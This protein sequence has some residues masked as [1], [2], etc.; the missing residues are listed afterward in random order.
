LVLQ[1]KRC[2]TVS[3]IK[4]IEV[5]FWKEDDLMVG[6][7]ESRRRKQQ[8]QNRAGENKAC[9]TAAHPGAGYGL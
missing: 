6:G 2:R 7:K 1:T 9:R 5:L 3:E 8:S 4:K